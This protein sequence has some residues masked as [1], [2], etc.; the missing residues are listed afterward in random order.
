RS[1]SKR[2][3]LEDSSG[4]RDVL[5]GVAPPAELVAK[6]EVEGF[7]ALPAGAS[8]DSPSELLAAESLATVIKV[9]T[10][11]YD[12]VIIDGRPVLP[13]SDAIVLAGHADGILL[14]SRQ[15]VTT[16]KQVSAAADR[17]RAAKCQVSGVIVTGVAQSDGN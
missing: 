8:V 13:Y 10:S 7:Y 16:A 11:E 1:A 12:L 2:L 4:L 3:N 5:E 14:V 6:T 17:A 9:L 15:N